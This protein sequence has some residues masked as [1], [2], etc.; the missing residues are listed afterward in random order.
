MGP[1]AVSA[2]GE[3]AQGSLSRL[4]CLSR[5]S[6]ASS[7]LFFRAFFRI[8]RV[9]PSVSLLSPYS[10]LPLHHRSS[11]FVSRMTFPTFA[12]IRPQAH[13]S[14]PIQSSP[15]TSTKR[16]PPSLLP[17]PSCPHHTPRRPSVPRGVRAPSFPG[18]RPLRAS[19][20]AHPAPTHTPDRDGIRE[21]N[22]HWIGRER[23]SWCC[24]SSRPRAPRVGTARQTKKAT[25]DGGALT[26]S[27]RAEGQAR[28]R[29]PCVDIRMQLALARRRV[30]KETQET[31][32]TTSAARMS[33][34]T[35]SS[36]RGSIQSSRSDR[37]VAGSRSSYGK[38]G[39]Q[40]V[41]NGGASSRRNVLSRRLLSSPSRTRESKS[42]RITFL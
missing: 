37:T 12:R 36:G 26:E 32:R 8:L 33:E 35:R 19:E 5:L 31:G 22:Q 13:R 1:P 2:D 39:H 29:K 25:V 11:L 14:P 30:H 6:L 41:L 24:G 40:S 21:T 7:P 18:Q 23:R 15:S 4:S 34:G 10:S 3:E 42:V 27:R 28:G 17:W 9:P 20:S 16:L 38:R